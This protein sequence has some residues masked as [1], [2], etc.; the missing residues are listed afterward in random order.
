MK[1]KIYIDAGYRIRT[2][3]EQRGYSREHLA[4]LSD[5]ST[6]FLYEIECGK[7][8]FSAQIL[9]RIADSLDTNCDYIMCGEKKEN[10]NQDIKNLV[11]LLGAEKSRYLEDIL[12]IVYEMVSNS[13]RILYIN[14]KTKKEKKV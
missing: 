9:K 2:I 7:K 5:I 4:E 6:K 11:N 3:R 8:G 13:L 12:H 14:K 10:M 1:N